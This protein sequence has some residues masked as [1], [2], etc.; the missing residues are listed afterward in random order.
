MELIKG[1]GLPRPDLTRAVVVLPSAFTLGNLFFG[2]WAIISASQG[3]FRW[4]A[5]YVMF[6]GILDMLD[7]RVARR[8]KTGTKFGAELDSL[9]DAISFGV[10]PAMIMY[11]LEFRY[12]GKFAWVLCFAYIV[13][14]VLRLARY[15]VQA[16][17]GTAPPQ[18][19][20]NGLPSPSAGMTLAV[21][22]PFSQTDWY[23]RSLAYLQFD[24]QG[25][26]ILMIVLAV[27]MVSTVRYPK[28]PPIGFRT[29]KGLFG[30]A[31]HLLVLVAG[32]TVPEYFFF[33]LGILYLTYGVARFALIAL[34]EKQDAETLPPASDVPPHQENIQ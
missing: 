9:V 1:R 26:V 28:F 16:A 5:W 8:T 6:A 11:F 15:N 4:A 29:V 2:I 19:W 33:P 30:A 31:F 14:V 21:W 27:M 18:G 20:F 32:L 12:A 24:R 23:Q 3:N 13:A 10:A 22:Y 34:S 17:S 7:G 25:L